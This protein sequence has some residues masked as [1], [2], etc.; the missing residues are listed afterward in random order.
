MRSLTFSLPCRQ[1]V[2]QRRKPWL[3]CFTTWC[4]T[5][6]QKKSLS[7][8]SRTVFLMHW[9]TTP[10]RFTK[11]SREWNM[12]MQCNT[13]SA[14][15][16]N[17]ADSLFFCIGS[18]RHCACTPLCLPIKKR[19]WKM[20]FCLVGFPSKQGMLW[21]G[22]ATPWEG[23]SLFGGTMPANSNLNDGSPELEMYAVSPKG[24]GL[25]SMLDVSYIYCCLKSQRKPDCNPSCFDSARV[26]LG[27]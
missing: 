24:S 3:G 20:M 5:L 22:Q 4:L 16:L 18:T 11:P 7:L 21:C 17:S 19:H 10:L 26:C 6:K 27:T 8:K 1:G 2:I 25:L 12:H 15:F 13:N 9:S 14:S 23:T